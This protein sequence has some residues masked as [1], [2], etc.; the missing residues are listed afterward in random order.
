M[1]S[2][3][4]PP[5][6]ETIEELEARLKRERD[7][8]LRSRLHLLLLIRSTRI[9]TRREAA[10]HLA[11]H[12]NSVR[13]WLRAYERGGLETMLQIGVGGPKPGQKSLPAPVFEALRERVSENEFPSYVAAQRWLRNEFGL[14]IP[15]RTVHGIIR[16]RLGAKLTRN[17]EAT[18]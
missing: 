17:S 6:H 10:E 2:K 8:R 9:K 12:R 11:V 4:F 1:Y 18:Q 15:Y 3:E 13:N 7:A 16:Y 5:I 14:D